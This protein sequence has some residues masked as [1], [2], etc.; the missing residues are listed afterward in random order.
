MSNT[1]AATQLQDVINDSLFP[2]VQNISD[3]KQVLEFMKPV[4]QP[5]RQEQVQAI[6]FLN[7][8]G[9]N[10]Y[11]HPNGNPYEKLI[12]AISEY[13][14]EIADPEFYIDTIEA[15]VPKPPKPI[16]MK[17]DGT[18]RKIQPEKGR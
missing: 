15:L 13:R 7:E 14:Q 6:L 11:I 17:E 18:Y 10:K 3:V 9:S 2:T 4:T 1:N 16:L 8:L 12:K 5:L